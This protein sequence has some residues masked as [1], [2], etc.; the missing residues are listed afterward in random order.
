MLYL[1]QFKF[2]QIKMNFNQEFFSEAEQSE[3]DPEI[4]LILF[5]LFIII[6][7]IDY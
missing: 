4:V 5:I 6:W 1:M 7:I 3:S 2:N